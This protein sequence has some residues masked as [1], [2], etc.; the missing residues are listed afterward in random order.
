MAVLEEEGYICEAQVDGWLNFVDELHATINSM[1]DWL[2]HCSE[3]KGKEREIDVKME[4]ELDELEYV[5]NGE[6]KTVPGMNEVVVR[7]LIPIKQDLESRGI[8]QEVQ[9]ACGCGLLDH[10]VMISNDEVTLAK[11]DIPV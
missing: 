5:S 9:E 4:E 6:Y 8:P 1:M 10:P 11:N 3:G 2:C 7:E